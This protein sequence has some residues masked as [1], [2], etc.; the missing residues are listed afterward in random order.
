MCILSVKM[1]QTLTG[2]LFF[3]FSK[4]IINVILQLA[5]V[6]LAI[7]AIVLYS[8]RMADIWLW[9]MCNDYDYDYDW[10]SESRPSMSPE[11]RR[12]QESCLRGKTF[13]LVSKNM[14]VKVSG[15][16]GHCVLTFIIGSWTFSIA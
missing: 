15:L 7:A 10:D 8:I 16:A 4:V 9:S 6:G 3:S 2:E 1:F 13:L 11:E 14:S 12:M 5:G